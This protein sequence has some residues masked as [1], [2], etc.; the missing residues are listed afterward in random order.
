MEKLHKWVAQGWGLKPLQK[1][2][3][4]SAEKLLPHV[5]KT[6]V[7]RH[8]MMEHGNSTLDKTEKLAM[9]LVLFFVIFLP[10][11]DRTRQVLKAGSFKIYQ[12]G[13]FGKIDFPG[14]TPGLL[15]GIFFVHTLKFSVPKAF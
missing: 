15:V 2:Q 10:P 1:N 11:Q 14:S 13:N 7:P 6:N 8:N 12:E 4:L 5:S 3:N 9:V